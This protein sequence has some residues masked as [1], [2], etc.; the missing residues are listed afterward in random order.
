MGS[1]FPCTISS[2]HP[3]SFPLWLPFLLPFS[4]KAWIYPCGSLFDTAQADEKKFS[5]P[6]SSAAFNTVKIFPSQE[7]LQKGVSERVKTCHL[8]KNWDT[9]RESIGKVQK[10][11]FFE[12]G[13]HLVIAWLPENTLVH[14]H[15]IFFLWIKEKR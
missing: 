10:L 13:S 14:I 3:N 12:G 5:S 7:K 2:L 8:I 6:I 9:W 15:Y 1:P 11:L 4:I